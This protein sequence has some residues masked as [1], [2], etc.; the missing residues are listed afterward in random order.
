MEPTN[1]I[2]AICKDFYSGYGYDADP[3]RPGKRCCDLCRDC[4][5]L[6]ARLR[7]LGL[8]NSTTTPA[9]AY[10]VEGNKE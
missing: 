8:W 2:C 6:P 4:I 7:H 5:V 9:K 10:K 3:V 1:K